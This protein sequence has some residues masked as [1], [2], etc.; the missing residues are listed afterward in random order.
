MIMP[1]FAGSFYAALPSKL[2]DQLKSCFVGDLGPG[3]LPLKRSKKAI[4]G[5]IVPHAGYMF[6]GPCA[7]WAY[8]ALAESKVSGTFVILAPDH[9]GVHE[10]P[11]TTLE[12][13]K[14]PL[15]VVMV[16]KS[17]VSNLVK[18]CPFVRVGRISEHAIEV[19]L[20]FLQ[21]SQA[22]VRNLRIVPIVIPSMDCYKELAE[23]ISDIDEDA[24][25]ICSSDFTHFGPQFDYVPFKYKIEEN[26]KGLDMGA[27][28]FLEKLDTKGFIEYVRKTGATICGANAI[29]VALEVLRI[30]LA[31]RGE[32]LCYYNS[33]K[34]NKDWTNS[35]G[36]CS[37][38]FD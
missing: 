4:K 8:K 36:Y 17:F 1:R 33:S 9:N 28:K 3:D 35:V 12:E 14:T 24:V 6:S 23:A 29:V 2:E 7:A 11:T 15:G 19:Q 30:S 18:R 16:D 27:A 37:M 38:R 13:F 5:V 32:L 25:I 31:K 21:F 22:D 10:F 34:V 26:L 20:P